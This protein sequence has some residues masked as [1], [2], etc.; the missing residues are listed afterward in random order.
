MRRRARRESPRGLDPEP[1]S[2]RVR[3]YPDGAMAT[4]DATPSERGVLATAFWSA[5]ETKLAEPKFAE[6]ADKPGFG[7][8]V[9]EET[10]NLLKQLSDGVYDTMMMSLATTVSANHELRRNFE[11]TVERVWGKPLDLL[12]A[13]YGICQEV[14]QEFNVRYRDRAYDED[15]YSCQALIRLHARS[16]LVFSEVVTLLRSGHASGA[17]ARWRTLHEI[18]VVTCFLREHGDEVA[19]RYLEHDVI[20]AYKSALTHRL[21]AQRL[22]QEGPTEE[23]F[24]E[25]KRLRDELV[26]KYG[27]A[28][29]RDYGWA[30]SVLPGE[31]RTFS[32]IEAAAKLDHMR[33]Y[34]KMASHAIHPNAR[35]LFFDLGLG[36]DENLMLAGPSTRGLADPG[37][38]A[39]VALY[40]ATV[41]LLNERPDIDELVTMLVLQRMVPVI[42][43]SKQTTPTTRRPN[44]DEP[45]ATTSPPASRRISFMPA[46]SSCTGLWRD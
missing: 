1:V 44:A 42:E 39:T 46:S 45:N 15:D 12:Y 29:K 26:V 36:D 34:Y 28:F 31:G 37:M 6:L 16:C 18:A 2:R 35:A 27:R 5:M 7:E 21:Y 32:E 25:V 40:Q 20:Q 11:S 23:E 33:P 43:D 3:H 14:G 19:R 22:G 8:A 4:E 10:G 9:T 38:G 17:H 30:A 41:S 13:F 24:D